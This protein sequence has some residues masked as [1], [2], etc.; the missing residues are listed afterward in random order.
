M[1]AFSAAMKIRLCLPLF[2]SAGLAKDLPGAEPAYMLGF[3][4]SMRGEAAY[5]KE[6]P[7]SS[8]G[9]RLLTLHQ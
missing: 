5:K 2:C 3:N 4:P 7:L 6:I 9:F 1:T 8:S